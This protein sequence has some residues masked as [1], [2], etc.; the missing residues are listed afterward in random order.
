MRW[1]TTKKTN[2]M[3]DLVNF[4]M[5]EMINKFPAEVVIEEVPE[6]EVVVEEVPVVEVKEVV[7]EE[8]VEEVV[9]EKVEEPE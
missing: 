5:N 3:E 8:E 1:V 9:E 7:I 6:E 4:Y 2:D